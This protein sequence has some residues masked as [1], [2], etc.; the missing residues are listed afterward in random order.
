MSNEQASRSNDNSKLAEGTLPVQLVLCKNCYGTGTLFVGKR[1]L[2]VS[3]V[4]PVCRGK[5]KVPA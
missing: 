2:G 1:R 4:C 3:R 5:T